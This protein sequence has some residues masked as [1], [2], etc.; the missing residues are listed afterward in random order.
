VTQKELAKLRQENKDLNKR[1]NNLRL[2]EGAS[3]SSFQTT[4]YGGRTLSVTT[5]EEGYERVSIRPD[6]VSQCQQ[7]REKHRG[8][9][10]ALKDWVFDFLSDFTDDHSSEEEAEEAA[11]LTAKK[12][13]DNLMRVAKSSKPW[14]EFGTFVQ[15]VLNWKNTA[16]SLVAFLIYMYCVWHGWILQLLLFIM[17]IKLTLNYLHTSGLA[18]QFGFHAQRRNLQ[19]SADSL[20]LSDKLHLMKQVGQMAQNSAGKLSDSLEKVQK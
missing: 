18:V 20:G 13:K 16:E 14:R 10:D 4:S 9:I 7:Q 3:V 17:L 5:S 15:D 6:Q 8:S 1:L 12:L 2:S 19:E 11:A